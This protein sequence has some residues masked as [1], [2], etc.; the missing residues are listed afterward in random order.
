MDYL[1]KCEK[2]S[3][4]QNVRHSAERGNAEKSVLG[5]IEKKGLKWFGE[6]K[7]MEDK[8]WQK[9]IFQWTIYSIALHR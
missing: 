8:L 2:L 1:R 7:R 3:R 5:W 4:L 9:P 6:L